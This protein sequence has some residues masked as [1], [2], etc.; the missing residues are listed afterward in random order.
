MTTEYRFTTSQVC[1]VTGVSTFVLDSSGLENGTLNHIRKEYQN[2][3]K[4]GFLVFT[5]IQREKLA[6][7]RSTYNWDLYKYVLDNIR[8]EDHNVTFT[9]VRENNKEDY[10]TL[11]GDDEMIVKTM[12]S[13]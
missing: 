8:A 6:E 9:L 3:T 12:M 2:G 10:W 11:T 7:T 4:L 1:K 5:Y 13:I